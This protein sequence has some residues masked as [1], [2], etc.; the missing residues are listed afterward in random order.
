MEELIKE[1]EELKNMVSES[2]VDF[3]KFTTKGNSAAGTRLR[4]SMANVRDLA[5]K[6]R[7]DVQKEKNS[8]S[9]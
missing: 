5:Q 6:I 9:K 2:E 8:E 3:V 7:L 4:K 1:F